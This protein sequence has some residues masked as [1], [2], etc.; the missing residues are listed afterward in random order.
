[1]FIIMIILF[2]FRYT[3]M[4]EKLGP[5]LTASLVG[6]IDKIEYRGKGETDWTPYGTETRTINTQPCF[7]NQEDGAFI[8]AAGGTLALG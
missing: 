4:S 2:Y 3:Y 5:A 7:E 1:M 8:P 6:C